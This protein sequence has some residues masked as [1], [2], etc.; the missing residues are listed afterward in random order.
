MVAIIGSVPPLVA[1][2]AGIFPFPA[3]PSPIPVLLLVQVYVAPGVVLVNVAAGTVAPLQIMIFAGTVTVAVGSTVIVYE[4]GIPG[5]A[6]AEGVTVIVAVIGAV[7]ALVAVNEGTF[8]FPPAPNPIDVLLFVH[9][10]VV[11]GVELVKFVAGTMAPLQT[12]I[13]AGTITFGAGL[14]VIV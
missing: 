12:S 1:V 13:S 11:P 3:A 2:K 9:V 7:P 10:N 8:P 5:Q 4:E 14:T 6:A